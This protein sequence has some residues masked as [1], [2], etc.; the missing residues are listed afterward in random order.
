[1]FYTE[2]ETARI[3]DPALFADDFEGQ[4]DRL[5]LQAAG[6]LR[7]AKSLHDRLEALY[8]PYVDFSAVDA[9]IRDQVE[10]L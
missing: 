5:L 7:E 9:L 2:K 10:R 6:A 1:M 4:R 3:Y 8:R